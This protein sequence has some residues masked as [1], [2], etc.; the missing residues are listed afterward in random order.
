MQNTRTLPHATVLA[1]T[2]FK[3]TIIKVR[4]EVSTQG[5]VA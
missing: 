2:F 1:T 5:Y 4:F 3:I